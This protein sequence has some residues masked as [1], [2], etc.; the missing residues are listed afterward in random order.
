[1]VLDRLSEDH[2][3]FRRV[4]DLLERQLVRLRKDDTPDFYLM[5]KILEYFQEYPQRCHHPA[6]DL[7]FAT[8]SNRGI[9]A[10]SVVEILRREHQELEALTTHL[11]DR[12]ETI[13]LD[14]IVERIQF[15][16]ELEDFLQQQ[17]A[18]ITRE[19]VEIFSQIRAVLKDQDWIEVEAKLC[20]R[21][22][23][24][25]GPQVRQEY[26]ALYEEISN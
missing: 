15:I 1:M 18:H 7:L 26:Q 4:L 11:K 20:A 16:S 9:G 23:P 22:D 2:R 19:E 12:V 24:V 14:G 21:E 17:R 13:L 25:F 6:E 8:Y 3:N 5:L 10:A